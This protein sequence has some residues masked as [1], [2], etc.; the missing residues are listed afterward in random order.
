MYNTGKVFNIQRFSTAD[1]PGIRTVVFLKGCPLDCAWC[2]N[3]ESKSGLTE[4]LYKQN[5][6]IGCGEC[7]RVCLHGAHG[8]TGGI[9]RFEREKCIGCEKC[10]EVCCTE[11]LEVCGK[12][13][14]A[15]EI[16]DNVLRDEPF[17]RESGGGITLSGGEPLMQYNFSLSILALAKKYGLHTAVETCGFLNRNISEI[18]KFTDLWLYDIKLLDEGEHIKFTGVSNKKILEN[19]RLLDSIGARIILR[20]PIIPNVNLNE[21][22]FTKL[23]KLI[24]SLTNVEAVNLEPYHPLGIFK[25]Q[26]IGKT[27]AYKNECFLNVAEI[28]P[29]AEKLSAEVKTKILII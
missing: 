14:S 7:N 13:I 6:C 28:K 24:N 21:S 22:H 8:F 25:A 20:C 12:E 10:A 3:P 4:I 17:Y 19:L 29:F 2:H 9:H 26:Q 23:A 15:E 5:C 1:G 18:N 16:I 11:A 27:Q